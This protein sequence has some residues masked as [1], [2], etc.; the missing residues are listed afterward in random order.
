MFE[1]S[2]LQDHAP[3]DTRILQIVGPSERCSFRIQWMK[4]GFFFAGLRV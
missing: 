1:A 4:S 3:S 2:G